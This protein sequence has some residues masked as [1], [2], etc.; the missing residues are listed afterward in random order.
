MT[1]WLFAIGLVSLLGQVVLLRELGV[2]LY[3]SELIYILALGFWLLGSAIGAALGRGRVLPSIGAI[4]GALLSYGWALAAALVLTRGLRIVLGTVPGAFPPFPRQLLGMIGIVAPVALLAGLLFQ[5]AA[6]RSIDGRRTLARAYAIE[7]AGALV[8]GVL[9]TLATRWGVQNFS[10]A[11]LCCSVAVVAAWL[12]RKNPRS[13]FLIGAISA[14]ALLLVVSFL[15]ARPLDQAMTAWNHPDLLVSRDSPYG[16]LTLT[17]REQQL[18]VFENDALAYESESTE[19]EEFVHIAAVQ[20]PR[21]GRA[22]VLGG[23]IEGLVA[24]LLMHDPE[25]V[26]YVELNA[27]LLELVS[28]H[29]PPRVRE[30][31]ESERVEIHVTD[32]RRFLEQPGDYDLILVGMPEPESGQTNR[33]YTQEFFEAC[34]ARLNDSGVLALR[35]RGAE[36]LWTP[37]LQR[38]MASIHRTLGTVFD[39]VVVLPGTTNTVLASLDTLSRDPAPLERRLIE[40]EVEASL[41]VPGYLDYLY[42]NDRFFTIAET[43]DRSSAPLNTDSRPICYQ[44]TL[45][46]WLSRFYL[47]LALVDLAELE[48]GWVGT[49][50]WIWLT[51]LALGAALLIARRIDLLRRSLLAATAGFT[52]MVLETLLIL[53]YQTARGVLFQDLGFLLTMFM[54]GLAIGAWAVDRR[55]STRNRLAGPGSGFGASILIVFAVASLVIGWFVAKGMAS[56]LAAV[57]LLLL[58]CGC[59]VAAVFAF[60]SLQRRHDQQPP[61]QRA[62]I[63]PL[64][65]AD[66]IGGFAGTLAAALV[67]IPLLG[68]PA[69][70]L[71]VALVALLALLLV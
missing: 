11:L 28:A 63:S 61:D 10:Q 1:L 50:P 27:T 64:Y 71:I 30:S 19:A 59:L 48:S 8:G 9:A 39:D 14:T 34:A 2:A 16:R 37:Q 40:R 7:S 26:D 69:S 57:S 36:N 4:R 23:G 18:S 3:G 21:V 47:D 51:L 38:R 24:E 6:K 54:A 29:Y 53:H 12:P 55:A 52:G 41:V 32:P 44:Y 45:L 22:L 33:F 62:I 31:L 35:L 60:A 67:L 49:S 15:S 58:L 5:W 20:R 56:S 42:S 70:A 43:L 66:L 13:R 46:L 25:R 65:A 68:M 17:S